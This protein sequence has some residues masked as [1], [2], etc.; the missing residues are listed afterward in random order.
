MLK[1][2]IVTPVRPKAGNS[3]PIGSTRS[4]CVDHG[5]ELERLTG[6]D[7]G[8]AINPTLEVSERLCPIRP[9]GDGASQDGLDHMNAP[10]AASEK[11]W[12]KS[13]SVVIAVP[14]VNAAASGDDGFTANFR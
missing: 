12:E 5:L 7:P 2:P 9:G 14:S 1:T 6:D 11:S 13:V 4:W 10:S 3:R 8:G